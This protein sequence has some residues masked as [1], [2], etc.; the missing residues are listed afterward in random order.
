MGTLSQEPSVKGPSD[1]WGFQ[2]EKGRKL[3]GP[4]WSHRDDANS[5]AQAFAEAEENGRATDMHAQ[6]EVDLLQ[7]QNET[8]EQE[9]P[10]IVDQWVDQVDQWVDQVRTYFQQLASSFQSGTSSPINTPVE[11]YSDPDDAWET[12]EEED[13]YLD[14]WAFQ[15]EPPSVKEPTLNAWGF[16]DEKGRKF[17]GPRDEA[18]V[19]FSQ[20][21]NRVG[22]PWATSV[23]GPN[24]AWG[25]QDERGRKFAGPVGEV[26]IPL[27]ER[28]RIAELQATSVKGPSDAW[29]FRDEKGRKFAEPRDEVELSL[30]EQ[31]R[32]AELQA[33]SVKS[34][35]D[36]WGFQDEKGRKFARTR[37][38]LR[39]RSR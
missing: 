33:T 12:S 34:P 21:Q 24:D 36:A 22:E 1:A 17:A 13:L 39:E 26:E 11:T 3:A 38:S 6:S 9:A 30:E 32:I 4:R 28:N 23:K 31:A 18:Q 16:Q 5:Q 7:E 35:N 25:F 37:A 14:D 27:E 2:D 19:E 8:A 20:K 10:S 29:G 15:D